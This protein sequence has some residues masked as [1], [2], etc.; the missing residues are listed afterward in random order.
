MDRRRVLLTSLACAL[1]VPGAADA[2]SAR[3]VPTVAQGYE[4]VRR[5]VDV[6]FVGQILG[7]CWAGR[8]G[9]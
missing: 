7:Q 2:Q 9:R 8:L 4:V 3:K 5:K 1:A 6:I